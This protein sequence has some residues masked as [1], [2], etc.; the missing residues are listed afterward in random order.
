MNRTISVTLR[1]ADRPNGSTVD[2]HFP[3]EDDAMMRELELINV[4]NSIT[5]DCRV[6]AVSKDSG[7]GLCAL[8]VLQC[9]RHTD[10]NVD[11]LN[12]LARRL[13]SF[14]Q[15][16]SDKFQ[17]AA[18]LH[19]YSSIKDLINLTFNLD[20]YSVIT[21]FPDL[22]KLGRT[23]Y[24]DQHGGIGTS[25]E[26]EPFIDYEAVACGFIHNQKGTVTPYGVVYEH[27][28]KLEEVYD[29]RLFPDYDYTNAWEMQMAVTNRNDP[30]ADVAANRGV[31]WLYLPVPNC[32]IEKTLLRLGAGTLADLAL[33]CVDSQLTLPFE[34]DNLRTLN[35][36]CWITTYLDIRG[37]DR[38][39]AAIEL[40]EPK[41]LEQALN[42]AKGLE[43]F[44]YIPDVKTP[45]EYG[46]YMIRESGHFEFDEGLDAQLEDFY[47][48]QRYGEQ[49]IQQERGKFLSGIFSGPL[50]SAF[51]KGYICYEGAQP[52]E[53]LLQNGP[54][55]QQP[56]M[57]MC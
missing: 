44:S 36:L 15:I 4:G 51:S 47:D 48:F 37:H 31:C 32:W 46:R 40:A 7:A 53:E 6:L 8:P 16:E 49:R 13:D 55:Q 27:G 42:L 43:L 11:E 29:G 24:M 30:S 9:L 33:D 3:M 19:G 34:T 41:T 17:A 26:N 5:P 56:T 45:E 12:Y 18:S 38:F 21:N 1:R 50:P 39:D 23:L 2:L 25:A 10:I 14:T 20:N 52:L 54:E 35:E 22:S 57:G 28:M